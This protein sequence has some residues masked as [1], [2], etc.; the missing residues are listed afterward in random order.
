ML[1]LRPGRGE[2]NA[3]KRNNCRDKQMYTR[4]ETNKRILFAGNCVVLLIESAEYVANIYTYTHLNAGT[5]FSLN[6]SLLSEKSTGSSNSSVSRFGVPPG[7]TAALAASVSIFYNFIY[8][9]CLSF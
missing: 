5:V 7:C 2:N 8:F 1:I 3:H 9:V 6:E 4:I